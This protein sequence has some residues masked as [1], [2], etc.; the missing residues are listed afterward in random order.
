MSYRL[1]WVLWNVDLQIVEQNN[2]CTEEYGE[3]CNGMLNVGGDASLNAD[4]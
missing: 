4:G 3:L 1:I 2:H